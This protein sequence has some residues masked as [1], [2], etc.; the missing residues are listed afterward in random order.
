MLGLLRMRI[1][2]RLRLE[3]LSV[4]S[5]CHFHT[6]LMEDA[7]HTSTCLLS[8]CTDAAVSSHLLDLIFPNFGFWNCRPRYLSPS[9]GYWHLL[10]LC[11]LHKQSRVFL[12]GGYTSLYSLDLWLAWC[13]W[14]IL[15]YC[16]P[17]CHCSRCYGAGESPVV[18]DK[19]I[20]PTLIFQ[21]F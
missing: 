19:A 17:Q 20:I 7:V 21:L 12:S 4:P 10:A 5:N 1:W 6:K 16:Q 11:C 3:T 18:C 13:V 9:F 15:C 8:Q 2:T 14:H